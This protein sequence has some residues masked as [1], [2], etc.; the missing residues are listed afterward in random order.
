MDM[1]NKFT[2]ISELLVEDAEAGAA[3]HVEAV[4]EVRDPLDAPRDKLDVLPVHPVRLSLPLKT[5]PVCLSCRKRHFVR[6]SN[7]QK[8][9][10]FV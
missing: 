1:I 10:I 5:F 8:K 6:L 4:E 7:L 9:Q 2:E 3:A